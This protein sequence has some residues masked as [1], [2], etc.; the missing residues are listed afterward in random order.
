MVTP[1][2][3]PRC[4]GV[5]G[6]GQQGLGGC[7]KQQ[8]I[9]HRLVLI[10]DFTDGCRQSE[11]DVVVLDGQQIGLAGLEPALGGTALAF[12]TMPVTTRSCRRS[13]S[14]HSCHSAAHVRPARR[15]GSVRWPT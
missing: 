10:R 14:G 6:D 8:V 2:R 5:G 1:M 4:F 12:G 9:D 11:H 7:L 13:G 15:C 3:V